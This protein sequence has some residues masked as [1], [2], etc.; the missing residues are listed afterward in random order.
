MTQT[1]P[2]EQ[3]R[4]LLAQHDRL[5]AETAQQNRELHEWAARSRRPSSSVHG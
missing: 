5:L 2:D 4:R 1:P 3:L